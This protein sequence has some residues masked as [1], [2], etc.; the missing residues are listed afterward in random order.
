MNP[1]TDNSGE[2]L[3]SKTKKNSENVS[4]FILK[5]LKAEGIHNVFLVPGFM[6]DP[7]L[8]NFSKA[9]I[10]AIVAAKEDGAAYMADGYARVSQNFGVCMGIG[11]PGITNMV[12]PISAAYGDRSSILA[13]AGSIPFE[14]S[15]KGTFQ[16]SSGT[17]I[18]DV[19]IMRNITEF[20]QILPDKELTIPFL[21]KAIRAMRSVENLP[22][23][24]SIPL[25]LQREEFSGEY[26]KMKKDQFR[27]IDEVSVKEIPKLLESNTR[28]AILVG[29]GTVLSNA[30]KE[31]EEFASEYNIPVLTTLRAKGAIS[32]DHP[33]SLGVF[34][35]GGT[36]WANR[37]II[38]SEYPKKN[39]SRETPKEEP[40][41][42]RVELLLVLGATLNE[43]NT[44]GWW[45]EFPRDQTLVRVDYNPNNVRGVE[46]G[47][48]FVM[49]D[50]KT[51]FSWM[52]SKDN[53]KLY[54]EALIKS[55]SARKKWTDSII[56]NPKVE[57]KKSQKSDIIPIHPARVI[58]ELRECAERNTVL[59]V[60]SG[61]HTFFTAHYWESYEPNEFL[62]LSTT[63]P[64][65]YGIATAIG[66]WKA[67]PDKPCV[68]VIGDGG[69]L[70]GGMELYT[71]VRYKIPIVIVVMNNGALGNVYLKSKD[72]DEA[73]P[74]TLFEPQHNWAAFA[75]SFGADGIV[76]E[77]P[78]E[79]ANAFK[80][81]FKMAIASKK[82]YL[83]DVRCEK[84][85]E[86]P[87]G[88]T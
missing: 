30:K 14:W 17:G 47:E 43:N 73:I 72:V 37:V 78:D 84:G 82:P 77:K 62:L 54:H 87:N 49:G 59:V 18:D 28:I 57:C 11:G 70:M 86:T 80:N 69:M 60:D 65:G 26:F 39:S 35:L 33:M 27:F 68:T 12:T 88:Y 32:E 5:A 6:I 4:F 58:T 48:K 19:A 41:P 36:L 74:Y 66:A 64:M 56:E 20:A 10:E 13:I 29:N 42:Q 25:D 8:E 55:K 22:A 75:K 7:F 61:A 34:G 9:G 44:H 50:V 85:I 31:I 24:L 45:S 16:D 51:F 38:G 52:N 40:L 79:L 15:G 21:K 1:E 2:K 67:R 63:G 3:I 83:V 46:Y 53:K 23:F 76:V 71:A 81:A